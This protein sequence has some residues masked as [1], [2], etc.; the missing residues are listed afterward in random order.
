MTS[1]KQLA[2]KLYRWI[3][4]TQLLGVTVIWL[5]CKNDHRETSREALYTTLL[6][7][8]VN[9]FTLYPSSHSPRWTVESAGVKIASFS[10]VI[11]K[12]N[13]RE[14][15]HNTAHTFRSSAEKMNPHYKLSW[16]FHIFLLHQWTEKI[17]RNTYM[18][19]R[20]SKQTPTGFSE[21][22]FSGITACS[23]VMFSNYRFARCMSLTQNSSSIVEACLFC[24]AYT[25]NTGNFT[26]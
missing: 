9:F 22:C 24:L 4:A 3:K 21:S 10:K 2:D 23:D 5:S 19:R 1:I 11:W 25:L 17:K 18:K 26:L 20:D 15:I 12:S 6:N 16:W 8:F 7:L 14:N 13:W